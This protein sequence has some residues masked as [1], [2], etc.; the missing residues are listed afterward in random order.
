LANE[1]QA[2]QRIRDE[3]KGLW[4]RERD[5]RSLAAYTSETGGQN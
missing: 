1:G 5:T 3:F 4:R 2:E